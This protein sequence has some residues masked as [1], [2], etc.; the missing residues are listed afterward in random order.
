MTLAGTGFIPGA[1]VLVAG[2]PL[3]PASVTATAIKVVI[4]ASLLG[5]ATVLDVRVQ[6]RYGLSNAVSFS[7]LNPVPVIQ[8]IS[9]TV[10]TAGG[11]GFLLSIQATGTV[12]STQ[13]NLNGVPVPSPYSLANPLQVPIPASALAQVGTVT[14]TLSNPA[15]GGGT[16]NTATIK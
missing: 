11:P 4:P 1:R 2:Y 5:T 8:S 15:P 10:V 7:V 3:P 16:S 12:S 6:T 9:T 14:V 13:V